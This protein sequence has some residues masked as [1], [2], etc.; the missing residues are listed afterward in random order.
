MWF[1]VCTMPA[2]AWG[3][4]LVPG[5]L[6]A[7]ASC[8]T[9]H[10]LAGWA[11]MEQKR[12]KPNTAAPCHLCRLWPQRWRQMGPCSEQVASPGLLTGLYCHSGDLP[13]PSQAPA[14]VQ[15]RGA[16]RMRS[17]TW[18]RGWGAQPADPRVPRMV[19]ALLPPGMSLLQE[20]G[21]PITHA[22]PGQSG[23]YWS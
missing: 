8:W 3:S 22:H 19:G 1:R 9:P 23:P 18:W 16:W 12:A 5:P 11:P 17:M 20:P 14:G 7:Q 4:F 6:Q 15:G 13:P 21:L 10:G 2:T